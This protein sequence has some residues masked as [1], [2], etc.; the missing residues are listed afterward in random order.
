MNNVDD[1][2]TSTDPI[3]NL[4]VYIDGQIQMKSTE[5]DIVIFEVKMIFLEL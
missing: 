2:F 3:L 1:L 4:L 5:N